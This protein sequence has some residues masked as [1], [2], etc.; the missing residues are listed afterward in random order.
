MPRTKTVV[1]GY[2]SFIDFLY[3]FD[4]LLETIQY[5]GE[6]PGEVTGI[7]KTEHIGDFIHTMRGER[8]IHTSGVLHDAL[9]QDSVAQESTGSF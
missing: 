1:R 4:I 3:F 2:D 9:A 8:C 5:D 7:F 6:N